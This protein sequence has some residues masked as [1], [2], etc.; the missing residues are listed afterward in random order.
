MQY[1][2]LVVFTVS[3]SIGYMEQE[4]QMGHLLDQITGSPN[5]G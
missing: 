1:L 4:M 3:L 2:L 5:V